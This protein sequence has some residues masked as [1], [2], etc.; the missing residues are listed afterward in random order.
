MDSFGKML[1]VHPPTKKQNRQLVVKFVLIYFF[2][3]IM[4]YASHNYRQIML[5]EA[6]GMTTREFS[7]IEMASVVKILASFGGT[8]ICQQNVRPLFVAMLA[9]MGFVLTLALAI[10]QVFPNKAVNIS[11]FMLH[12]TFDSAVLPIIDAECLTLLEKHG[13]TKKFGVI[14]MF[15]TLGHAAAYLLNTLL[16][17]LVPGNTGICKIILANTVCFGFFSFI[18]LFYAAWSLEAPVVRRRALVSQM[19]RGLLSLF[20]LPF[21]LFLLCVLGI[22]LSRSSLQSYLTKYLVITRGCKSEKEYIYFFRT[23]VELFVWSF[24]IWVG[25]RVSHESIFT[26]AILLGSTRA[27]C[28]ATN[29]KSQRINRILPY[30]AESLKS[31]YSALFIFAA[32]NLAHK[33]SRLSKYK[34]FAQGLLTGVYSGLAP[35]LAGVLRYTVPSQPELEVLRSLFLTV[36]A[37]GLGSGVMS[38]GCYAMRSRYAPALF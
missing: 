12:I 1:S 29:L 19:D 10:T 32:T 38:L 30:A 8:W 33:Y 26:A 34:V 9:T 14:R 3:H 7:F 5:E 16:A 17:D 11:L 20:S 25:D 23:M 28:Y 36:G 27:L 35:F 13:I 4:L 21:S 18:T 31:A 2:V 24:V 6:F 22:G 15:S 37:I